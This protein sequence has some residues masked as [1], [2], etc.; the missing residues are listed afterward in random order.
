MAKCS[1]I[2]YQGLEIVFTD[3]SN[4]KPSEAIAAFEES[5]KIISERPLNTVYSLV[6]AKGAKINKE[7]IDRI[8]GVVKKN[9]AYN[10][11][12]VVSGLDSIT[13]LMAQS[14]AVLTGRNI[15]LVDTMDE[16]MEYLLAES[17]R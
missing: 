17:R 14:I 5:V 4:A 9:N 10:K 11:A 12:T 1:V 7:M 3:I 13:K 6:N 8:K 15:K 2:E 16:A